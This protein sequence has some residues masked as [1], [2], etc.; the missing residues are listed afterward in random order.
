MKRRSYLLLELMVAFALLVMCIVPLVRSP[1]HLMREHLQSIKKASLA[2]EAHF[3]FSK[4]KAFLYQNEEKG[5]SWQQISRDAPSK[6]EKRPPDFEEIVDVFIP[7]KTPYIKKV[8]LFKADKKE[9]DASLRLLKVRITFEPKRKSKK[10]PKLE[11]FEWVVCA[12][13]EKKA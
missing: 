3:A 6:K 5:I 7:A 9:E 8:Y 2:R 10:K 13:K 12:K 4:V 11:Q 1:M